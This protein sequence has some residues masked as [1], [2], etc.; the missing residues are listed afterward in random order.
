MLF[1]EP[2]SALDPELVG[3]VLAVMRMLAD[4]GMTMMVVTHEMTFAREVADRVVFMDGG[5]I[6]EDGTPGQVIGNPRH[7]RTRHFLSRLLD[8]AMAEVEVG[9]ADR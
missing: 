9:K 2:T 4:E 5:V 1:D 6:V 8:P 7:E 3:D